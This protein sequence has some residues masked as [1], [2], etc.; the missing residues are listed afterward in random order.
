MLESIQQDFIDEGYQW[1][2]HIFNDGHAECMIEFTKD[3]SPQALSTYPR[4]ADC[5]G[6]GRFPRLHA[7]QQAHDWLRQ[8]I[9]RAQI[10]EYDD[11]S[12]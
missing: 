4:P 3:K 12:C 9:I 8:Q 11:A 6:W 10:D 1:H 2:E 5:V 7:W